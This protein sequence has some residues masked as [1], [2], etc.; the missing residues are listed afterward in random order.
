MTMVMGPNANALRA[1]DLLFWDDEYTH[2]ASSQVRNESTVVPHAGG[3]G[4]LFTTKK[5]NDVVGYFMANILIGPDGK[6][7][8]QGRWER[9]YAD[10]VAMVAMNPR[11]TE[12]IAQWNT[13]IEQFNKDARAAFGPENAPSFGTIVLDAVG[14]ASLSDVAV[15]GVPGV[16]PDMSVLE[17]F[18]AFAE[19]KYFGPLRKLDIHV[20]SL[21]RG[22]LLGDELGD[23]LVEALSE[24]D[25]AMGSGDDDADSAHNAMI[26]LAKAGTATDAI[27]GVLKKHARTIT[28]A[29]EEVV[30]DVLIEMGDM[31]WNP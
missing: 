12:Q 29:T 18:V 13:W 30:E 6:S 14:G 11:K 20:D 2:D 5:N 27:E 25:F 4:E 22:D 3:T 8:A 15:P 17:K 19:S 31:T 23:V 28:S 1:T 16:Q 24:L 7:G 21:P 9:H 10:V 26:L